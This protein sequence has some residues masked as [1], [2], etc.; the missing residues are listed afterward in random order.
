ME[1]KDLE[2]LVK[3]RRLGRTGLYISELG[4][5]AMNLRM[6]DSFDEAKK[7][8]NYVLDQGINFI[9][10]ARA[11]KGEI[12]PGVTLES[13]KVVGEV[14]GSRAD[15]K[16]PIVII[17]KGHGYTIPELEKDLAES[18]SALGVTGRGNLKIGGNEIKLVYFIHGIS[19]ERWL[20]I[21]SSG[22]LEKL[23]ALKNEGVI[24]FVG[25]SSH[26]PFPDEI[27][28]AVDT[29]VFDVVELP[30]N[31]FDR[32]LGEDGDIDLLQYIS[33]RD[34]GLINMKAFNG[35]GM[36]PMFQ[37]IKEFITTDYETMLRFSLSNPYITSVDAGARTIS[38]YE[39]DLKTARGRRFTPEEL[40]EVKAEADK[41]SKYMDNLC[42]ECMHC[43]EKFACPNQIDFQRILSIYSRY[44]ILDRL[45]KDTSKYV[46]QYKT[47][48]KSGSDCVACGACMPWCE[49]K[50]NIPQM[51]SQAH[52]ALHR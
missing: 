22:V 11:Y 1:L 28:E 46:E 26:Y 36:V 18:L 50:L 52:E 39:Q 37:V 15:L 20:T 51:L 32:S 44:L 45:G 40:T 33:S 48:E 43:L 30:Y 5:G 7:I 38:E 16:E 8:L 29:G 34:I 14:I 23:Q 6:L 21:K 24:N 3:R 19:S 42:R 27:K 49:Y 47:L 10:T 12:A 9:D 4:Y 35:N 17:T 13:E 41:V 25:F 2:T 31:V